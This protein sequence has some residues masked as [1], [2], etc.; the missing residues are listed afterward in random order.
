MGYA[1]RNSKKFVLIYSHDFSSFHCMV[2][3]P[4][5]ILGCS[6]L[7]MQLNQYKHDFNSKK[8]GNIRLNYNSI[9]E[10]MILLVI[11]CRE[12]PLQ[13]LYFIINQS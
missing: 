9:P 3:M 10:S 2:T 8:S 5:N 11:E 7:Y 13:L 1:D 4:L 6:I 12:C